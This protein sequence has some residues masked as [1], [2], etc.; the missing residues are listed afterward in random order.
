[1]R[2]NMYNNLT[3]LK[4]RPMIKITRLLFIAGC[5]F[6]I[7]SLARAEEPVSAPA[8]SGQ[9]TAQ[10]EEKFS[11]LQKMAREYRN[12]GLTA[13]NAG[14]IDT[15]MKFYQKAIELDPYF[16]A[17]YNDLGVIDEA[18]GYTDEAEKSYIKATEIDPNYLS[19]Y[20]NLALLYENKRD[21]KQAAS[22]WQK[23]A[24]LGSVDDPWTERAKQRVE[25]LREVLSATPLQ[26]AREQEVI[27]FIKDVA[28]NKDLLN[29]DDI[30]LAKDHFQKAKRRYDQGDLAG[31]FQ[32]ALDAQYLDPDNQEIETFIDK[33]QARVLSK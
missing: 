29:H 9:L 24:R 10:E 3:M 7:S 12:Q 26:D 15:A 30:F 20:T 32:E 4:S 27:G 13:Q 8:K 1:M 21:L 17:P 28:N 23:R 11:Q 5:V 2:S 33:V 25:D 18:V 16:A 19:A 31:A 14:D 22:C 6:F